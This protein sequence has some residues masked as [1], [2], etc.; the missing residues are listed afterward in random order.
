MKNSEIHNTAPYSI[1]YRCQK[2]TSL[3]QKYTSKFSSNYNTHHFYAVR[4]SQSS[5]IFYV[6]MCNMK[7]ASQLFEFTDSKLSA[8]MRSQRILRKSRI[9]K[10]KNYILENL[11]NYVFSS[12][13]VSVNNKINFEPFP[14]NDQIGKISIPQGSSI[15][16]NDGQHRM[17]AIRDAIKEQSI[18]GN[19]QISVV[20][21]EDQGLV[22]SQQMFADLNRHVTKPTKS[23][24][25]LFDHRDGFAQFIVK[26]VQTLPIFQNRTDLE[27]TTLSNRSK[28]FFTLN[29]V[30]VATK[31]FLGRSNQITQKDKKNAI[32]FWDTV[33]K[34]ILDWNN[35]MTESAIH[36]SELRKQKVHAHTN[37]HNTLGIVG[38]H[39]MTDFPKIWKHHLKY[40]REIEWSREDPIWNDV[41]IVNKRM[42]K[43]R[44]GINAAANIILKKCKAKTLVNVK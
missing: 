3:I 29:G 20:F 38:N 11:D 33:S 42:I 12:I 21:F 2:H 25:I 34:N 17:E 27:N 43:T 35:M 32:D 23:L 40:L 5:R 28:N 13:T 4:G 1:K 41:V 39:L 24:S 7:T 37:I 8:N 26:L 6:A 15:L 18:L 44:S 30:S 22:K 16:I 19:D 10:I 31:L 9:P 14:G 36:P